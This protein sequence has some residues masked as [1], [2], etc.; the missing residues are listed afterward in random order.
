MR[1]SYIA[2]VLT[3]SMF[4]AAV[5][6]FAQAASEIDQRL[7]YELQDKTLLLRDFYPGNEL[8]Y[9]SAGT[10]RKPTTSGNWTVDGV[11]R[12][13]DVSISA[14]RLEASSSAGRR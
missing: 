12:I 7:R 9:D 8:H 1:R 2:P 13:E 6:S 4:V 10:L 3:L 5:A 11:V 14:S